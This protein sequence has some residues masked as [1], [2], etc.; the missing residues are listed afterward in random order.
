[1][2]EIAITTAFS[3]IAALAAVAIIHDRRL[4]E[5]ERHTLTIARVTEPQLREALK[6]E[7]AGKSQVRSDD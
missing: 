3:L 4:R 6:R 7:I 1:M 5:V 2:T